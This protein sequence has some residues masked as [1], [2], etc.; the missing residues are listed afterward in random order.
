M[1]KLNNWFI[2]VISNIIDTGGSDDGGTG[3]GYGYIDGYID[4]YGSGDGAGLLDGS[5]NE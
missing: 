4:G 1:S 3:D 5:S 2:T